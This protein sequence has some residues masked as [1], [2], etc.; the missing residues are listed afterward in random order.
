MRDEAGAPKSVFEINTDISKRVEV[1]AQLRQAQRL[2][3]VGQLTGGIAHDFNNLLTVILGN[4]E[5]LL[6]FL[7]DDAQLRSYADMTRTAAERGAALTSRLLAFARRQALNPEVID[8]NQMLGRMDE[9]LRRTIG[10]N[11]EIKL[12][13]AAGLWGTLVDP[14]QLEAAVLNLCINA[15]DAM[16]EGGLLTIETANVWLDAE[17]RKTHPEVEPGAYVMLAVSDTGTG[18]PADMLD[19]I[20]EPFFTTKEVGKGSG[21][22]LSMVYGFVKQSGGHV[23]IYSEVDRG[24]TVRVY[25]RRSDQR[26]D[27]APGDVLASETAGGSERILLVED[28]EL[29]RAHVYGQLELLGYRVTPVP[30]GRTALSVLRHE[31]FDLLFT[32]VVMPG[33]M[34]GRELADQART[35]HPGLRVLYTSGYTENAIVHHGQ[36]DASAQLLSKPYSRLELARKLRQ[37]LSMPPDAD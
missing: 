17:Y 19:R 1:E 33:G 13:R 2:E 5:L 20:F 9:L 3:A 10:G 14:A 15:R 6:E 26:L 21:L 25:L 35:D 24:T 32:D 18:I 4:A 7:R 30:D 22:G 37:V 27:D 28:D 23:R 8:V 34:N 11:I 31:R 12:I 16:P 36:L 29:V